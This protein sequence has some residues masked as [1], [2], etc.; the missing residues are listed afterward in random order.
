V[1]GRG[2]VLLF[3]IMLQELVGVLCVWLSFLAALVGVF[4][5]LPEIGKLVVWLSV[6]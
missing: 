2:G 5:E 6:G 3:M 1:E 4:E